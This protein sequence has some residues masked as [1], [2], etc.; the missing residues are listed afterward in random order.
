M[1]VRYSVADGDWDSTGTWSD[2]DGGAP[3]SSVPGSGDTAIIMPAGDV[4]VDDLFPIYWVQV[5]GGVLTIAPGSG[6]IFDDTASAGID[7]DAT[8]TSGFV[9]QGTA[10]SPII[11]KSASADPTNKWS[12]EVYGIRP[13]PRN[14]V[15]DH[16]TCLGNKW[17][18]GNETD[19][20]E[21]NYS[22]GPLITKVTPPLAMPRIETHAIDGREG[23][24]TY[25]NGSRSAVVQ[26]KGT[27]PWSMHLWEDLHTMDAA[28]KR[29]ALIT[30]DVHLVRARLEV[31]GS[32][33]PVDG[34]LY[35]PFTISLV[36]DK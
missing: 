31:P 1:A 34:S 7:I 8:S 6:F 17:Y 29:M 4:L 12:W 33:A 22:G 11:L 15:F 26:L 32:F 25:R 27:C 5:L 13:D 14:I 2:T 18:L 21:F 9:S 28:N 19:S 20:V 3:G 23:D 35:I 16:M 36:E 10:A 30:Q 24:R